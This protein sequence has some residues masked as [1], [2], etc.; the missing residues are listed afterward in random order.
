MCCT[1][2]ANQ[3]RTVDGKAHGQALDGHV[4]HHL[5]VST[6]QEGR[7][8]GAER[9]H[10]ARSQSCGKSHTVLFRNPHVERCATGSVRQKG[11]GPCR[12]DIAAV[13]AHNLVVLVPRVAPASLPKTEV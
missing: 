3:T 7:I 12:L 2:S 1:V 5:I 8:H 9:F 10:P 11:S 13:T 4:M 6:L